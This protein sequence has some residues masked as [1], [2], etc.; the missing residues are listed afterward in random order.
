MVIHWQSIQPCVHL[1][2]ATRL[3]FNIMT[4]MTASDK[5]D[6]CQSPMN[7]GAEN[8]GASRPM[9]LP[10]CHVQ[11]RQNIPMSSSKT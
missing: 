9:H 11:I 8:T 4:E 5:V 6:G 3:F 2:K 10:T 1:P 7:D